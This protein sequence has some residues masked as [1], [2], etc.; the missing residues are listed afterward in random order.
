MAAVS[1][2]SKQILDAEW[3]RFLRYQPFAD[4]AEKYPELRDVWMQGVQAGARYA[5]ELELGGAGQ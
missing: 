3:R 5:K 4:L 2:R 1:E